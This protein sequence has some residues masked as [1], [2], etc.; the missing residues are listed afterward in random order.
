M[1]IFNP[2]I[3]T[4]QAAEEMCRDVRAC[5]VIGQSPFIVP[6]IDCGVDEAT[7][8]PYLVTPLLEGETLASRIDKRGP[9]PS[10]EVATYAS[11]LAR[12]L[13]PAHRA[14]VA[15][16]A[17]RPSNL[18]LSRGQDGR[19]MIMILD[20]GVTRVL[21]QAGHAAPDLAMASYL[22]PEQMAREGATPSTDVWP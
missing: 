1:K 13:D 4:R 15:H 12:S 18:F 17:L 16:G 7:G 11:P 22:A 9:L 19:P 6:C 2:G 5:A 10:D 21:G 8:A 20:F 14:N 3:V